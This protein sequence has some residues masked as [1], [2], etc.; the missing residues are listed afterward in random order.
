[1]TTSVSGKMEVPILIIWGRHDKS[2]NLELGEKMH[3][4]LEGSRLEIIEESAHCANY[5]QPDKFSEI[6]MR[7]LWGEDYERERL[8][9]NSRRK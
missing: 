3:G 6:V 4:M 1:L 9:H 8:L 5:E 7:F 2:V